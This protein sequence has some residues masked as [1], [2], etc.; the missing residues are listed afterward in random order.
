MNKLP[1]AKRAKILNLL[2]EGMS[3]RAVSRIE[4]VSI[5]TVTKLLV[6]AGHACA[7]Y[8]DEAVRDVPAARV[9]CDEIWS[10]CYAKEK[11]VPKIKGTPAWAGDVWTWTAIDSDS[12]LILSYEVGDRSGMTALEFMDDLQQRLSH[13][14]Q[15]T[16]DGHRVYLEAVEHAFGA[17]VDYAQ[18]IKLYGEPQEGRKEGSRRYSPASCLGARKKPITGQ[19]D[20]KAISTSHVERHNLTMRM[21]MRRFTRLTNAF[22]KIENHLHMLSLYFCHYNWVRIHKSLRMTPAMAAGISKTLH[23]MEWI[24]GLIDANTPKPGPRGPYKKRESSGR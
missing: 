15:L 4:D 21:G 20:P 16:T 5:N 10:F 23:D 7:K 9:Q 1:S 13:R 22:S 6:D 8:H 12:K 3:M 18:L 17:D 14:V 19:P 2:I 11:N 24:V